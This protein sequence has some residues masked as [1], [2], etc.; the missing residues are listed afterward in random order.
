MIGHCKV[1]FIFYSAGCE[2]SDWTQNVT[3]KGFCFFSF[4]LLWST[5]ELA[6]WWLHFSD[7]NL[8]WFLF[9]SVGGDTNPWVAGGG[10]GGLHQEP[11]QNLPNQIFG[12]TYHDDP[13]WL[14]E[15]PKAIFYCRKKNKLFWNGLTSPPKLID[16][17]DIFS[18]IILDVSPPLRCV[19]THIPVNSLEGTHHFCLIQIHRRL[20]A[21]PPHNYVH[22]N[23]YL[24]FM[25]V[26]CTLI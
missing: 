11:C 22:V 12:A 26:P 17:N 2:T 13:L 5:K 1:N 16:S 20:K 7:L 24:K 18:D 15:Q 14:D 3:R 10:V 6:L 23:I 21:A 9:H 4:F 19:S 8:I 25:L